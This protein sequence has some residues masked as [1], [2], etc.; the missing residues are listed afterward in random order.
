VGILCIKLDLLPKGNLQLLAERTLNE[1]LSKEKKFTDLD[2]LRFYEYSSSWWNEF[3]Q[4]QNGFEFRNV[5]IYA[6]SEDEYGLVIK[7][8]RIENMG[9]EN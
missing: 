5:K 7:R 4:I 8:D 9:K 2:L 3:R 6:E 1:Q